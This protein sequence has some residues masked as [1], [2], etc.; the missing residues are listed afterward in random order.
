M[1]S[2][3]T[4]DQEESIG[5]AIW[6]PIRDYRHVL[7]IVEH[8]SAGY[9]KASG[10]L[11]FF[12]QIALG[13]ML[14]VSFNRRSTR[15]RVVCTVDHRRELR[16]EVIDDGRAF[17]D[18]DQAELSR[19]IGEAIIFFGGMLGLRDKEGTRMVWLTVPLPE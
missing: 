7:N 4:L 16:L 14:Q 8:P 15:V 9:I 19:Q 17:S 2:C 1:T 13:T 10:R 3:T 12:L 6:T 11:R 18:E 5:P